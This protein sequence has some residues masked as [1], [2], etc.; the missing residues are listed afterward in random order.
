MYCSHV[1]RLIISLHLAIII[2]DCTKYVSKHMN[3]LCKPSYELNMML[4][5]IL[6]DIFIVLWEITS[7]YKTP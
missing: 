3:K 6:L 2:L 7:P 1:Y 5:L 4:S